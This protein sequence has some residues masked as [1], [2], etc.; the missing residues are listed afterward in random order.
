MQKQEV[1]RSVRAKDVEV[2]EVYRRIMQ[3][4]QKKRTPSKKE[5]DAAWRILRERENLLKQLDS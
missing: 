2:L 5:R 1:R 4:R 3:A